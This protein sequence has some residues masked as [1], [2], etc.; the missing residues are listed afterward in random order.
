MNDVVIDSHAAIWY[1]AD[2]TESSAPAEAAIDRAEAI[3]A[4]YVSAMTIVELTYLTE[5]NRIPP[6]VINLLR[7]ALDDATTSFRLIEVSREVADEIKNIPRSIVPDMPDRI[8]AATALHLNPPLVT[9]DHKS[10]AL[11]NVRTIW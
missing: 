4:I 7:D 3:G 8:V 9:K 10:Q 11:Q 5:K 6:D 2:P 1:F